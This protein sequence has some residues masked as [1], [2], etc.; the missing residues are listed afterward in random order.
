VRTK[1]NVLKVNASETASTPQGDQ[2]EDGNLSVKTLD[3]KYL[4]A[5]ANNSCS[6]TVAASHCPHL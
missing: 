2:C 4:F 6:K 5:A 1:I 3:L